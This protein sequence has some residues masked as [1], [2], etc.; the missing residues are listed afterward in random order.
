MEANGKVEPKV[1]GYGI[2]VAGF[3]RNV[4][5]IIWVKIACNWNKNY[6]ICIIHIWL[7]QKGKLCLETADKKDK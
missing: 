3:G 7:L 1:K 2:G 4:W 6:K 5:V